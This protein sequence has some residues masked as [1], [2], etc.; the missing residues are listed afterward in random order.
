MLPSP[1]NNFNLLKTFQ[2]KHTDFVICSL[3]RSGRERSFAWTV[4]GSPRCV[5]AILLPKNT[6][7]ITCIILS[8][9]THNF[10]YARILLYYKTNLRSLY[11]ILK[12]IMRDF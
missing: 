1:I 10:L 9:Q 6:D 2:K 11:E 8:S 3:L 5:S 12:M 4:P 7:I